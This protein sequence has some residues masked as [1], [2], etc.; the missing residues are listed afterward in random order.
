MLQKCLSAAVIALLL[1]APALAANGPRVLETSDDE[2]LVEL[3]TDD[4][5][6]EEVVHGGESY[7]RVRVPLYGS[8]TEPGLPKLP[9]KGVLLGV[10][11]GA[12]LSL[13]V[14]SLETEALG[15]YRIEPAPVEGI[16]SDEEFSI[17]TE[18]Y[19]PNE[20]FYARGGS[21]PAAA[22]ELGAQSTFRHQR[23]VQVLLSPFHYSPRTG[24]L[25]LHSRIVVR[26]RIRAADRW[27][28]RPRGLERE[29]IPQVRHEPAWEGI[30]SG[31]ILNYDQ[32]K[33]WRARPEPRR[34]HMRI[35]LRDDEEA[36][37][38]WIGETGL[39]RVSFADLAAEGLDGTRSVDEIGVYR[40][41]YE[42]AE[43]DPFVETPTAIVV[44]DENENDLFDGSDYLYFYALSFADGVM[45]EGYEDRYTTENVY[46]FGWGEGVATR[47]ETTPGW[48]D[49]PG[50]VPPASFRDTLRF[51]EDVYYDSTPPND[52][53]DY[54]HWT[55]YGDEDDEYQLPFS[56][57]DIDPSGGVYLRARYQGITT[58]SHRVDFSI[59]D[60]TGTT[61]YVDDFQFSGIS[62]SM[63]EDVYANPTSPIP[64]S[65][66]TD[67]A[68]S[69]VAEG[70]D[71]PGGWS[72]ANLDWFEFDYLRSYRTVD[73]RLA[74]TSGG[75]TG[76][77]QFEVGGF[78]DDAIRLFDVTDPWSPLEFALDAVNVEP[79]GG[80]YRLVFQTDV[81]GFARYEAVETG[82]ALEVIYIERREPANL[83]SREADLIVVSYDGHHNGVEPLVAFRESQ[84]HVVTHAKLQ[85]VYDEF[86]GG[87]PSH[88]AIRNLFEYAMDEWDRQP[89]WCLLVGDANED[90]KQTL[91]SSTPD[92]LPT[93]LFIRSPASE[94]KL[95]AS[96]QWFI[97][98]GD[99]PLFLP[100]MM[101][102]RL[103]VG[104]QSQLENLVQKIIEY[105]DYEPD[106]YWRNDV[107]FL[108]DDSWSYRSI[109]SNYVRYTS[110]DRFATVSLEL[111]EMVDANPA[112]ID[113]THFLLH[114]FTDPFH[115]ETT[116]GDFIYA[117]ETANYVR[118]NATPVMFDQISNGTNIVNFEGHGNRTQMTHEQLILATTGT[119]DISRFNNVGR[120]FIFLGWSCEL[121]RFYD[122]HEGTSVDCIVEQMLFRPGGQG[123]IGTFACSSIAY[124]GPNATYNE[125]VFEAFFLDP[126]PEGSPEDNPWPRWSLGGVVTKGTV[127][128]ITEQGSST[129]DRTYILLGDPMTHV[130]MSPPTV[131]VTI[132]GEP[133]VSGDF[134]QS[135]GEGETVTIL[136]DLI[137]EVEIDPAS[138]SIVET[139]IG[140][141]DPADYTFESVT[142]PDSEQ[143][144]WYRI[145]YETEIRD[146]AYDILITATDV[147]GQTT[148][149]VIHVAEGQDITLRDVANHPNPFSRSTKIIYLLNQEGAEVRISIYT[150][151]GRLIRTFKDASNDL[152]YNEVEWDGEDAQGDL[153]ANGLY[154]YVIEAR[155]ADGSTY[156][157][158]VGRMV[159]VN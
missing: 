73:G 145:V 101:I 118:D 71:G 119:N 6:L 140:T 139:D 97:S 59:K 90:T 129:E 133:F 124:L 47:M 113:T 136:A 104:P 46:W 22:A 108:A 5:S 41:T 18:E 31:T 68:N 8:T 156:A 135:T 130:E 131:Q 87:L 37:R 112:G 40:R 121:S 85:E 126:T 123:A 149:F 148:T 143:S 65:Y 83:F 26:V 7:Y 50:L 56:I 103:P 14:V 20:E 24:Q 132:D 19:L 117:F 111:G 142:D 2:I 86:N 16:V 120:P 155:G 36:Y 157:T 125:K 25:A 43:L 92:Y 114:R 9:R 96:D 98:F 29:M 158:P 75:E 134:L 116:S 66:F 153:V 67:G 151:G 27:R 12:E 138:V 109:G 48:L 54:Y 122:S 49:E 141:V 28:G 42:P 95:R 147:N 107:Y 10:P 89:Q 69:L 99:G 13:E 154:L 72:G 45:V 80:G 52:E 137:D 152:N 84:G 15:P 77:S 91:D 63:D 17:A 146:W 105:E 76:L 106:D 61:N 51:E 34:A 35:E 1:C 70:S 144:R 32:A 82:G 150:V 44:V 93:Y 58:G 55:F 94:P 102:G 38:L 128:V 39:Y 74:C 3:A 57:H 79:Q 60:G 4:Y 21:Y 81:S 110:E 53:V 23:V 159:K 64:A 78:D 115:G 62:Y 88:E 11:F 33:R 30:Y 127:K 100:Q